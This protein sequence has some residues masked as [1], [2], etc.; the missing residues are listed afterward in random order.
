M[1]AHDGTTGA[2]SPIPNCVAV[3]LR[4][5]GRGRHRASHAAHDAVAALRHRPRRRARAAVRSMPPTPPRRRASVLGA[6]LHRRHRCRAA[7]RPPTTPRARVRIHHRAHRRRRSDRR[8]VDG[9]SRCRPSISRTRATSSAWRKRSDSVR[10]VRALPNAKRMDVAEALAMN[11][12]LWPATFG[13]YARNFVA[14]LLPEPESLARALRADLRHRP[15]PAALDPHRPVSRTASSSP[16]TCRASRGAR[17]SEVATMPT[18]A[19]LDAANARLPQIGGKLPT[20][21][22]RVGKG[23]EPL[24]TIMNV[25]GLQAA[26]PARRRK[27]VTDE[28]PGTIV[29]GGFARLMRDNWWTTSPRPSAP[30]C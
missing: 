22:A 13:T 24:K 10:Q 5:R 20:Q 27:A 26:P 14:S 23:L 28:H 9:R 3:R 21:V 7:A 25:I 16:A 18:S 12:A 15:Q 30:I 6:S 8:G 19:V 11:R 29:T 1:F 2:S 4:Q 17:A